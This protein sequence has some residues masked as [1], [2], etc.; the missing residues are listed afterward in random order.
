MGTVRVGGSVF[1]PIGSDAHVVAAVAGCDVHAFERGLGARPG[2]HG[3][4]GVRPGRD[5]FVR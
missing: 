2:L 3:S 1:K 5:R 4:Q